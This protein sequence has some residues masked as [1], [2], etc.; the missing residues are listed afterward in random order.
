MGRIISVSDICSFY[1]LIDQFILLSSIFPVFLSCALM[2]NSSVWDHLFS[3][4]LF[5]MA[6]DYFQLHFNI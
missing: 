5:E 3:L 2:Q 4:K 6:S 1:L